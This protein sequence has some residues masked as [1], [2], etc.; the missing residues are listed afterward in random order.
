MTE[1]EQLTYLNS[2]MSHCIASVKK[3][4]EALLGNEFND[5]GIVKRVVTIESKLKKLD[6]A[7]Y[8]LLGIVT[9]GAYP[10][11]MKMLVPLIKEYFK[12]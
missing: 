11:T 12:A 2:Q 5:S 7:F 9:C 3:I 4:E 8:I 6:N 1:K 10:I